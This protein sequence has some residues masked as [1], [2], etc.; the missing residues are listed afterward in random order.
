[1]KSEF[2]PVR[3]YLNIYKFHFSQV[4]DNVLNRLSL[5][6]IK[7]VSKN[8]PRLFLLKTS[9]PSIISKCCKLAHQYRV[10]WAHRV[11]NERNEVSP[12]INQIANMN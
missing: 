5:S 10:V 1:M 4:N 8:I 6:T 2:S 3:F 7:P 9:W 12:Q 11:E